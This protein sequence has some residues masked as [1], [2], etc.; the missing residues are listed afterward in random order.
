MTPHFDIPFRFVGTSAATV[1]QNSPKEF[2]NAV[3]NIIRTPLGFRDELPD[4]GVHDVL[5]SQAPINPS[6]LIRDVE[7]YEGRARLI[8]VELADQI[9]ES[10]RH[11]Q[12]Q[13]EGT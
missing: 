6:L 11:I 12:I 5:F 4:F 13:I 9:D 2:S 1:E 8:G 7:R 10:V 3:E